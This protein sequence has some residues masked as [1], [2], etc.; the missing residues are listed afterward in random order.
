VNGERKA[1]YLYMSGSE[2][3]GRCGGGR[4]KR[5]LTGG[6]QVI[7]YV[8]AISC[9][10]WH[11]IY[12]YHAFLSP[13]TLHTPHPVFED[14]PD[15]GF[16]NVGKTQFDAGKIPKRTYTRFKTQ[17]KFEIKKYPL[18]CCT[19]IVRQLLHHLGNAGSLNR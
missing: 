7:V 18:A 8:P 16:R 11:G 10:P 4:Y 3:K 6:G 5:C 15:R 17:R 2:W 12:K 19:L 13:F 14:G 1:W 9:K